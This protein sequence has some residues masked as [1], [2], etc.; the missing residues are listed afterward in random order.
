MVLTDSTKT[1]DN[2]GLFGLLESEMSDV[3]LIPGL[4]VDVDGTSDDRGRVIE[5]TI[6][7]DGDDLETAEMIQSGLH[8]TAEQV[9]ANMG[10]IEANRGNISINR[11]DIATLKEKTAAE[12]SANRQAI[13]ENKQQTEQNIKDIQEVS[14]A[15]SN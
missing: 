7:V 15:W 4:K 6:T 8:P 12:V 14:D 10:A 9:A 3:V 11:Q 5:Q 1:K 13:Q 2:R